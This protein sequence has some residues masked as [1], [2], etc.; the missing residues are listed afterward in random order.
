MSGRPP[1]SMRGR[2]GTAAGRMP[3]TAR[4]GSRAGQA[5]G[6]SIFGGINVADRLVFADSLE[7]LNQ[8]IL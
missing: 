4:P 1:S 2:T 6:A 7:C 8:F 5:H 3:G